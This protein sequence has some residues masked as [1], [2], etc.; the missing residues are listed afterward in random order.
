MKKFFIILITTVTAYNCE[1]DDICPESTLTT[2][3]MIITFYDVNNPEERKNVESL[4]VY[5]VKNSELTLI[6]EIN[7]INTDSIAIP[8]RDDESVSNFKFCKDFSEDITVIPAGL[9]NHLYVDYE[10]YE[11]FVSRACGFINNYNLSLTLPYDPI[12]TPSPTNWISDVIILND[13]VNNE[14]QSH[15]KILH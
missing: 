2:P 7:G 13:S 5:I 10:I 14:N 1:S 9:P 15:V 3:K 6:N 4:G 8:L 11:R 12:N